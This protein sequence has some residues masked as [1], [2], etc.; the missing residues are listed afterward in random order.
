MK[1]LYFNVVVLL[2]YSI[3]STTNSSVSINPPTFEETTSITITINGSS[4]DESAWEYLEMLCI[5][6]HGL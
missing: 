3:C 6:G 4:V 2:N 1:K 5:C